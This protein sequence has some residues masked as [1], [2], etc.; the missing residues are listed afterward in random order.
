MRGRVF[1]SIAKT[2][3]NDEVA[4]LDATG[5]AVLLALRRDPNSVPRLAVMRPPVEFTDRARRRWDSV[6]P[7]R[8]DPAEFL[9]L[10][11]RYGLLV[12][13][14]TCGFYHLNRNDVGKATEAWNR[15]LHGTVP[16]RRKR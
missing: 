16:R 10:L 3:S 4:E 12:V 13:E 1:Y 11:G 7:F 15:Q 5:T 8:V 14:D 2:L 6:Q 9:T